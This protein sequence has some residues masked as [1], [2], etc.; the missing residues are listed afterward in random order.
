MSN[1][2]YLG[3]GSKRPK[4]ADYMKEFGWNGGM[5]YTIDKLNYEKKARALK[6]TKETNKK[7]SQYAKN[8]SWGILPA[9]SETKQ[10]RR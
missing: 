10:R 9:F 8:L 6:E 1:G 7:A 4:K 3:N 2:F 5:Y